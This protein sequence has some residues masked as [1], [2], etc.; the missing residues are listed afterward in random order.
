METIFLLLAAVAITAFGFS[1][2]IKSVTKKAEHEQSRLQFLLQKY[3]GLISKEDF[4]RQLDYKIK[5]KEDEMA[6]QQS[7]IEDLLAKQKKLTTQINK[8]RLELCDLEE[9]EYVQSFGFYQPKYDFITSGDYAIQ[10]KNIR[11]R[12]R[13][14]IAE[15]SAGFRPSEMMMN[16][17]L[18][19]GE[20]LTKNFLK[21][22]L[23]I[24]NNDCD[25]AI[26]KVRHGNINKSKQKV[27]KSFSR[28][29]KQAKVINC[30]ITEKYLK[31]K[32]RELDLQY[33]LE[34]KKQKEREQEQS[35]RSEERER[36]EI[37]KAAK[38]VEELEAREQL[39]QIEIERVR[40]EIESAEGE[41]RK[42]LE[43]E[44]KELEILLSKELKDKEKAI[45]RSKMLKSGYIYVISNIDSFGKDV[46]RICK[47]QKSGDPDDYITGMNPVVP[48][49]FDIHYRFTSDEVLETLNYLRQRFH[50]RRVNEFN[51]R[52]DFFKVSLDEI[53]EA[54]EEVDKKTGALKNIKL[55]KIPQNYEFYRQM[56]ATGQKQ[57]S[58]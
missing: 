22:I 46:Y 57:S 50:D 32:L 17:N 43:I 24:F 8:L 56:R 44:K 48:F 41:K 20:K 52:R 55:D 19:A 1:E 28:L 6:N 54:V 12:Q 45:S 26:F 53:I 35:I 5:L 51:E 39:R 38:E 42:Q 4:E 31:L 23:A 27:E 18:K 7:E 33:E 14:M 30:G 49:P 58:E 15:E 40:Q 47:T 9:E 11:S 25:D 16:D 36:R 37:E 34:C 29:N 2:K 13:K 3:D 21:L 10:L